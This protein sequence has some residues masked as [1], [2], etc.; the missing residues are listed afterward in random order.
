MIPN[1]IALFPCITLP[2]Y[3]RWSRLSLEF[4]ILLSVGSRFRR[5]FRS[6]RGFAYIV[7]F[8]LRPQKWFI[9]VLQH[10]N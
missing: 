4:H 3:T 5:M 2:H 9:Y 6:H 10:A 1:R 7:N 8:V